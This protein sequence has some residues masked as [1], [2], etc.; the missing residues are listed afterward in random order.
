MHKIVGL[1]FSYADNSMQNRGMS[2]LGK[3]IPFYKTYTLAD[4]DIPLVKTNKPDGESPQ[5]VKD[6]VAALEEADAIV[7]GISEMI[8]YPCASFKNFCEW[9]VININSNDDLTKSYCISHKPL[10]TTTF[11]PGPHAGHR[12]WEVSNQLLF[13]LN[14][15]VEKNYVFRDAW[16]NLLPNNIDYVQQEAA[17]MLE[18][19]SNKYD[20]SG[21]V[22]HDRVRTMGKWM[23]QYEEWD[24]EWTSSDL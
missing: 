14:C 12:H 18:L 15:N 8:A 10:V 7:F 3:V 24:K 21:I 17:E 20:D 4:F 16:E 13:Q 1:S 22:V 5:G 23:N 11:T 19:L 2:L 6:I 9:L